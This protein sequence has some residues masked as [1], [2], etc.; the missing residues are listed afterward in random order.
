MTSR[1]FV[2][3]FAL[4][5]FLLLA[6]IGI[7]NRIVDPAWYYRDTEIKGFNA[8]KPTFLD[9]A[10]D[11]KP[12]LLMRDQPEAIILGSSYAEI[13]FDPTNP[14][15]NDHDRLKSMNFAFAKALWS[16]VQCDFEFAV[17]HSNIKRALVG[18]H[19]GNLPISNC[20]KDFATI[21]QLNTIDILLTYSALWYSI[22][23]IKHQQASSASHTREGMFFY[24]RDRNPFPF[25]QEDLRTRISEC[26]KD[27]N[28]SVSSTASSTAN[29]LDLS[30]LQRMIRTAQ[31][32]GVELVLFAYPKHAY[33]LELDKLCG[34]QDAQWQTM[35]RIAEFIDSESRGQV[36]AWQ[37]YGYND[38]TA[39]PV[40]KRR[41]YWQDAK[42]FNFEVGNMMLEDMFDKARDRPALARP[43]DSGY[44]DF[45]RER[46][47][48]LQSHPEFGANMQT[49]YDIK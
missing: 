44:E 16:E 8:V 6:L 32:H 23:T 35:R 45:L 3:R 14:S 2:I 12:V 46:E 15:F 47:E 27:L 43:L 34:G 7:F 20:E 26:Q 22:E 24:N 41:G 38:I 5:Y 17:T 29:A 21:G 13:G 11:V 48:Y 37:F 9:F 31:A 42:H 10:R 33:L 39:K 36:R 1:Q 4:G 25:F 49:M 18:F 30:G 28:S 19:P 40:S